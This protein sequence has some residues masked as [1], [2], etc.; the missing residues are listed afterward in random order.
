[1]YTVIL[2]DPYNKQKILGHTEYLDKAKHVA[3]SYYSE[4]EGKINIITESDEE[5]DF[6]V[7]WGH[8]ESFLTSFKEKC[9]RV[10]Y[11]YSK[12]DRNCYFYCST[13]FVLHSEELHSFVKFQKNEEEEE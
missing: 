12:S 5:D 13:I 2:S 3:D 10:D 6:C 11:K 1:M 8:D 7:I 9:Y 4:S